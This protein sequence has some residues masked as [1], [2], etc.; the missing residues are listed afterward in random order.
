MDEERETPE[1][2]TRQEHDLPGDTSR[3]RW[4]TVLLSLIGIPISVGGFLIFFYCPHFRVM[5][6]YGAFCVAYAFLQTW[7]L[8]HRKLIRHAAWKALAAVAVF[9]VAVFVLIVLE[10]APPFFR[11]AYAVIP[12]WLMPSGV[13]I[14]WV[15]WKLEG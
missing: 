8:F 2:P 10:E 7:Y 6:G 11:T 14:A 9:W 1:H 4:K 15:L 13:L 5:V 3:G 12:V